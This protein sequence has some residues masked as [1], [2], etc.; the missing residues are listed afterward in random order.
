MKG[1]AKAATAMVL[2]G[3]G[4]ALKPVPM[5]LP[6]LAAG[7]IL[8]RL[9]VT[10]ICGSDVHIWEGQDPRT[11]LPMI[12]GH[13]ALGVIA[14][15]AGAKRDVLG[16]ELRVGDVVAWNRGVLCGNCTACKI[17]MKPHLCAERWTY[18][19]SKSVHE[20]PYLNG[21]YATHIRL[22]PQ[23]ELIRIAGRE[24]AAGKD[25]V[26][27]V[28]AICA[29]TT[30]ACAFDQAR[31]EPGDTVVIQG[32]GPLGIYGVAFARARG[33]S[34]IIVIGGTQERLDQCLRAGA[35]M[36]LNRNRQD[37]NERR[38]CVL[39]ATHGGGADFVLEVAGTIESVSEGLDLVRRGGTYSS[40][41][42]AV[43]VGSVA[44]PWFEQIVRKNVTIQGVWVGDTRH[45]YQALEIF[46]QYESV[47]APIVTDRFP[48]S[49]ATAA[50]R[51]VKDKKGMKTVLVPD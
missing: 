25:F 6:D 46:R 20:Y 30:V 19:I 17:K 39:D 18:G 43:P 36:A 12:L 37:A 3:Y 13:E 34:R 27:W 26:P 15:A 23:T 10:G 2:E 28:S 49:Q 16:N 8:C 45:T 35:T 9:L 33:A 11:H 7:E 22:V 32:P 38:R 44:I 48:L 4:A 41:G 21:G 31:V 24:E 51:H 40:A 14:E 5:S 42:I 1:S 50:L 29:G 47:L